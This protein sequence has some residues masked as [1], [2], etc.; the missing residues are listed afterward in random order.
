PASLF[1][2]AACQGGRDCFGDQA[3]LQGATGGYPSPLVPLI[4]L[5]ALAHSPIFQTTS[6]RARRKWLITPASPSRSVSLATARQSAIGSSSASSRRAP[7]RD[8]SWATAAVATTGW[9]SFLGL[10]GFLRSFCRRTLFTLA[11]FCLMFSGTFFWPGW[12]TSQR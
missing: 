5:R 4:L 7:L 11:R 6:L 8:A 10:P 1:C 12:S 2:Q 3:A 9:F